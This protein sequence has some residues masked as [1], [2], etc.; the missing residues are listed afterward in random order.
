MRLTYIKDDSIKT[1]FYNTLYDGALTGYFLNKN[2]GNK[3]TSFDINYQIPFTDGITDQRVEDFQ[4]I[5]SSIFYIELNNYFVMGDMESDVTIFAK[6]I[7][8][9]SISPYYGLGN[10]VL[11]TKNDVTYL[12]C[13]FSLL[14]FNNSCEYCLPDQVLL[15]NPEDINLCVTPN[16]T[17]MIIING[18]YARCNDGYLVSNGLCEPIESNNTKC[19]RN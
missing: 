2:D 13:P 11:A 12:I 6:E 7:H 4:F 19:N 1:Y 10:S 18:K 8:F 9:S 17:S 5:S 14:T 3:G 15:L 16:T